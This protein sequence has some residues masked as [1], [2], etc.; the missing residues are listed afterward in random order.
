MEWFIGALIL[1]GVVM[2]FCTNDDFVTRKYSNGITIITEKKTGR[3]W[4]KHYSSENMVEITK[5]EK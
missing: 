3:Q 4:M 5:E 2:I 1:Y